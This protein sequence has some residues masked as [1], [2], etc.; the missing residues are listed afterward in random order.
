[1][2]IIYERFYSLDIPLT[3]WYILGAMVI[4][5]AIAGALLWPRLRRVR[6][7]VTEDDEEPVPDEG[8]PSV[9][10][11]VYSQA[12]GSNL[13]T[14]LPQILQQDYPA[15]FEVIVVNDETDDNTENIVSELELS[16]HSCY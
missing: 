1:M 6:R 13:R 11:I 15:P 8:Y 2:N 4:C 16:L 7:Q 10:V 5:M 14:L 12:S 3:D 9:S